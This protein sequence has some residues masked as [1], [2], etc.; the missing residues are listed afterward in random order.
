V[1]TTQ[2]LPLL[3]LI[4]AAGAIL[5]GV[6]P[7]GARWVATATS[8]VIFLLGAWAVA[9]AFPNTVS[10]EWNALPWLP[11][12]GMIGARIDPLSSLMLLVVLGIGLLVV[13]FSAGYVNQKN[14][15]HPTRG[16]QN[17]YYFWLLL[18]IA[19]MTGVVIAPN[20]L[21]LFIFWEITTLCSWALISFYDTPKSLFAGYKAL[22]MTHIGGLFLLTG[23]VLLYV[24]THSFDFTALNG[25]PSHALNAFF[26][27]TLIGGLAKA[28]QGPFYTWLPDAMEAPTPVSAY[29]HAAA[30]V[31]AGIYLVARVVLS[32]N[33]P[34]RQILANSGMAAVVAT[35]AL[36]TMAMAVYLFFFQDD[37]KRL[38]ALSTITHL[39]YMLVGCALGLWGAWSGFQG[40]M[41]HLA[42]HA[43]GKALLF[44]SIGALAYFSGSKKISELSGVGTKLPLVGVAFFVGAFTVTGVPPFGGF[45]SKVMLIGAAFSMGGIGPWIGVFLLVESVVAF[46]WFLWV[47]QKVFFGRLSP[48]AAAIGTSSAPMGIA[49]TVLIA[50]CLGVTLIGLPIVRQIIP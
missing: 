31:K 43:V 36:G 17:R 32:A 7:K 19:A 5:A 23:I 12:P 47:G 26:I 2:I 22:L 3:P 44:L 40:G 1:E 11:T 37:L 29:L 14:H 6:V 24:R 13:L 48:V 42:A 33:E 45:F 30:M 9:L 10:I 20:F 28:A 16:G 49:L 21:Q 15:D 35:V 18:F 8:G 25:L 46:A 34:S 41:L 38:L 4:T 39:S 50:L 27:L